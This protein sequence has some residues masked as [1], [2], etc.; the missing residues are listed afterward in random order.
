MY[1]EPPIRITDSPM[2]WAR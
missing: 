1:V 2:W